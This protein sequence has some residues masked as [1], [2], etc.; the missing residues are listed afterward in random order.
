MNKLAIFIA[1]IKFIKN[2]HNDIKNGEINQKD[3]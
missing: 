1:K 2:G 3:D